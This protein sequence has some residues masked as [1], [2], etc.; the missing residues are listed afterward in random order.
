MLV[1]RE[2]RDRAVVREHSVG[3]QQNIFRRKN[4]FCDAREVIGIAVFENSHVLRE[5]RRDVRDARVRAFIEQEEGVDLKI[6]EVCFAP[7]L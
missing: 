3:H 2:R 4:F 6:E 7:V 5:L 1:F